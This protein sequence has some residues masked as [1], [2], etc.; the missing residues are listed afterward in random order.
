MSSLEAQADLVS[1]AVI[2]RFAR[3]EFQ[4]EVGRFCKYPVGVVRVRDPSL[5]GDDVRM[6]M[7]IGNRKCL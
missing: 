6:S 3:S 5:E 1:V 7:Q 2:D 4:V